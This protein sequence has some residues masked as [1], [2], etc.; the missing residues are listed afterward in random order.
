MTAPRP[1]RVTHDGA[2]VYDADE[3]VRTEQARRQFAAAGRIF[4]PPMPRSGPATPEEMSKPP[5]CRCCGA[6]PTQVAFGFRLGVLDDD[7]ASCQAWSRDYAEVL[8]AARPPQWT[9]QLT[10]RAP[11]DRGVVGD[12]EPLENWQDVGLAELRALHDDPEA[13]LAV[14]LEQGAAVTHAEASRDELVA[15]EALPCRRAPKQTDENRRTLDGLIEILERVEDCD[16][17][18]LLTRVALHLALGTVEEA[19]A[20]LPGP[21][22]EVPPGQVPVRREKMDE[23]TA[24]LLDFTFGNHK[25]RR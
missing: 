2:P 9:V 15:L 19:L 10:L 21:V 4:G 7:C 18:R 5:R 16:T 14:A 3:L 23:L 25:D 11:L 17:H 1:K 13:W 12:D 6:D 22:Q 24:A 20:Q 8:T